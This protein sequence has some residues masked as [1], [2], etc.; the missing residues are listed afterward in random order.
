MKI[1]WQTPAWQMSVEK[2]DR[3][4]LFCLPDKDIVPET[5]WP[6]MFWH[7]VSER[8]FLSGIEAQR[9]LRLFREL[10]PGRSARCH[11]PPWG[12][13]L[14]AQETL[15]FTVTLCYRCSNAYVYTAQGKDLRAFNPSGPNA[16]NLYQV[17]QEHLPISE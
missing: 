5:G 8:H 2:A 14:Y 10:E 11:M 9:V 7:H 6:D 13:A 17:L 15:L 1:E 4:E 16:A 3:V 12:L